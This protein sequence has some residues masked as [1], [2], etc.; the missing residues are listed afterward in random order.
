MRI[1]T[2][3]LLA[4]LMAACTSPPPQLLEPSAAVSGISAFG[5]LASFGTFEMELAPA[6]T[7]LAVLRHN[8]ALAL[9]RGG[10]TVDLAK[11]IQAGSDLARGK[12]DQSRAYDAS[13]LPVPA[14]ALLREAVTDIQILEGKLP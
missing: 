2:I 5:T 8:A 3:V 9:N 7:R 6:Y 1:F 10:I 4:V 14:D 11:E 13:K 12:L